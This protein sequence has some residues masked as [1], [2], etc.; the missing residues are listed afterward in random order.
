[1]RFNSIQDCLD[2]MQNRLEELESDGIM[3]ATDINASSQFTADEH[4]KFDAIF[5]EAKSLSDSE[6][7]IEEYMYN[8][9]EDLGYTDDEITQIFDYEGM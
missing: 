9:L 2:A 1:M 8:R 4:E 6:S 7:E 5:E 3:S